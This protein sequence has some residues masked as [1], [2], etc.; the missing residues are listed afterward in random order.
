MEITTTQRR[1]LDVLK[2]GGKLFVFGR[3]YT[4]RYAKPLDNGV[5]EFYPLETSCT[6]LLSLG[7]IVPNGDESTFSL[8]DKGIEQLTCAQQSM[9]DKYQRTAEKNKESILSAMEREWDLNPTLWNVGGVHLKNFKA[10]MH[11]VKSG[12]QK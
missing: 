1:I 7:L 8:T 5:A 4:C 2:D 10:V 6:T 12:N 9:L 3:N 11:Y